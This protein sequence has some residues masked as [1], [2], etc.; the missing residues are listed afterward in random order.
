M[1]LSTKAEPYHTAGSGHSAT[2]FFL[3]NRWTRHIAKRAKYTTIS[4]FRPEHF[5]AILAL[6]EIL[7]GFGRH[8]FFRPMP[9][10]WASQR[11]I[12]IYL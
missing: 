3:L 2:A 12:G 7:A 11:G 6:I 9:T 10:I 8:F 1:K 4:I 5:S